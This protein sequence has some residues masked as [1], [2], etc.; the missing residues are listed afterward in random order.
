MENKKIKC[1]ILLLLIILLSSCKSS[2]HEFYFDIHE[3]SII[4]C[5][6]QPIIK[7]LITNDSIK[8]DGFLYE[9]GSFLVWNGNQ[10]SAPAK[11][12]LNK[13]SKGY[14]YFE[15]KSAIDFRLKPKNTYTI[16]KSGGGN[17]SFKIRI[18]TDLNGKIYKTTHQNC[19]L[20][21]LEDDGYT[22]AP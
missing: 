15:G 6:Q 7:L 21:S 4:T 3:Q 1:K 11:L 10:S 19:G 16:E 14:Y 18:W 2:D 9:K 12:S 13:I 20:K 5:D 17:P 22:N 8:P